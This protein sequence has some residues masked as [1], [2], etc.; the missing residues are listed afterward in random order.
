MGL[1][2]GFKVLIWSLFCDVDSAAR[3]YNKNL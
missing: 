2:D 3:L 1:I